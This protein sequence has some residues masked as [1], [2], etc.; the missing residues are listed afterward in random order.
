MTQKT[1]ELI[2]LEDPNDMEKDE[3]GSDEMRQTI[4]SLD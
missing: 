2:D 4:E 3:E 1:I